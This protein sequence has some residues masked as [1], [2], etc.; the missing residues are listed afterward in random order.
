[1][2]II[3]Q[4]NELGPLRPGWGATYDFLKYVYY[5]KTLSIHIF[6]FLKIIYFFVFGAAILDF[7]WPSWIFQ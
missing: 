6:G 5:A 7:G 1:M 4:T 3:L 2:I